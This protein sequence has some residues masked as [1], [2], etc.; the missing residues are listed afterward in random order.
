MD[1]P[2]R[3]FECLIPVTIC[4][5][6]CSYC[7]VIQENNRTMKLSQLDYPPEI[8]AKALR[9]ERVGGTCFF[10]I[11]GSGET[12]MQKEVVSIVKLLLQEGHYVNITTNGTLTNRF[13]E[14]ISECPDNIQHL[15]ISFSF[16]YIELKKKNLLDTFFSNIKKM[17]SAGASFLLQMNLC[18][19]YIPYIDEIKEIAKKETG[20]YPQVA[21]T[22]DESARPMQI[23]SK[24][25]DAEYYAHGDKFNSPLFDF[26]YKNFNVKRNEFCYAGDWS[27]VLNL[28]TGCLKKCYANDEDMQNIF[29]DVNSP[30]NFNAVGNNCKN[31]YCVNSSHFMSL[32]IIPEIKTPTYAALRNRKNAGW[33]NT[34]ME[35][36]LSSK[37]SDSHK[38][39]SPIKKI[40]VNYGTVYN[41][42]RQKCHKIKLKILNKICKR[43]IA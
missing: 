18:D 37:L 31:L 11:C 27:F 7:Y 30:I 32:G 19:D 36:F 8:I 41:A 22:R 4:N 28:Q 33:Y 1:K 40:R 13:D 12:L 25:T 17:K 3:F 21:L 35:E 20:A 2:V 38:Q 14:I 29:K 6:E 39:Y 24:L 34:E 15:H 5:L 9:K 43:L 10:S 16:H 26:T 23:M 42:L